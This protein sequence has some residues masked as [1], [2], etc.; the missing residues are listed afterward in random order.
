[1]AGI[2]Q[3][4]ADAQLAAYLAAE[5]AVLAGQSYELNGRK[6]TRADLSSIQDGIKIWNS[7]AQSLARGGLSVRGATPIG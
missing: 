7:R 2:T 6:V 3:A 5:T 4:Q 1:M